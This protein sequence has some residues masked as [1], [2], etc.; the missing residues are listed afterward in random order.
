MYTINLSI[1]PLSDRFNCIQDSKMTITELVEK[2][3]YFETDI[4]I[5][6]NV[7]EEE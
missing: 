1:T 4:N 7:N 2:D 3:E 6:Y 5:A